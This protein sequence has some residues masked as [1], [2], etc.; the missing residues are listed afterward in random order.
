MEKLTPAN[1]PVSRADGL[2][3]GNANNTLTTPN[4][5]FGYYSSGYQE[6]KNAINDGH[7]MNKDNAYKVNIGKQ[8]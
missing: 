6:G 3:P 8:Q 4:E 5:T 7:I 1:R 2:M